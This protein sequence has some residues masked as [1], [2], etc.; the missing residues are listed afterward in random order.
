MANSKKN[1]ENLTVK[2]AGGA[3]AQCLALMNAIYVKNRTSKDFKI[4][5]YPYSTGTFWPFEIDF[6][7]SAGEKILEFGETK[8]FDSNT[9]LDNLKAGKIIDRHPL[10]SKFLNYEK[11]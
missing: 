1:M 9:N 2:V 3:T 10:Q 6:L 8:G 4:K 7:L 5:Y 11:I